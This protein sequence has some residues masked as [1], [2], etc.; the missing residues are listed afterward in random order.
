M[1][2]PKDKAFAAIVSCFALVCVAGV[3]FC[4]KEFV[5][6]R[7]ALDS[8]EANEKAVKKLSARKLEF[9]L[10]EENLKTEEANAKALDAAVAEKIRAIKGARGKEFTEK[11]DVDANTFVSNLRQQTDQRSKDLKLKKIALADS[12][13]N[14]GFSR[15]LQSPQTPAFPAEVLPVLCAERQVVARLFDTLVSARDKAEDALRDVNLLPADKHVFLLVKDVRREAA[16]LPVKDGALVIP[17]LRDEIFISANDHSDDTG[18]FRLS[19]TGTRGTPFPSLRRAGATDAR[20][21]Q[22]CFV[23]PTSVARNFITA[24]SVNGDYPIYVRDVAVSPASTVDIE[25]ARAQL[26]PAPVVPAEVA[27]SNAP[28]PVAADFDIFG[29]AEPADSASA[30]APAV[31]AAPQKFVV[32]KEMPSEFLITFEYIQPVEKKIAP[33]EQSEEE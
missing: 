20:A 8:I 10:T 15:Y 33:E 2:T 22:I 1:N 25:T 26:D 14:F 32:Q 4:V 30:S 9:A 12:A 27:A 11:V 3:G 31:P 29:T 24:F 13:K 23:A 7:S 28:A 19:G 21:F 5:R 6:N 17:L 18:I 16:E